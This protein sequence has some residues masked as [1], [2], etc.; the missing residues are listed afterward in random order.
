MTTLAAVLRARGLDAAAMIAIRSTLHPDDRS[1]DFRDIDDV[2][3]AGALDIYDRMQDGPRIPH[4]AC[5]LSFSAVAHDRARLRTFRRFLMRRQG[6]APGDI[7]YHY[8]AAHLLH[9][10]IA[11]AAAP[12]FYDAIDES[13]CDELIGRLVVQWPEDEPILRADDARLLVVGTCT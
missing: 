4:D 9:A 2:A 1:A 3:Q 8:D 10:F 11:R 5:V 6:N 7:V 13:G 12:V